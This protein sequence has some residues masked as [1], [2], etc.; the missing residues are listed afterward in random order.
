MLIVFRHHVPTPNWN[1]GIH[2]FVWKK[3][4][5]TLKI[6][7][8]RTVHRLTHTHTEFTKSTPSFNFSTK[9]TVTVCL[10]NVICLFVWKI[11]CRAKMNLFWSHLCSSCLI[12]EEKPERTNCLLSL[13]PFIRFL[14]S[15]HSECLCMFARETHN[16]SLSL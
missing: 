1:D 6:S 9:K 7:N 13:F 14:L 4:F 11:Q 16:C 12:L 3:K 5:A 15:T 2:V 10:G 8:G